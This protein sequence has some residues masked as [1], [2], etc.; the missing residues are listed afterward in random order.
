MISKK[1]IDKLY[2]CTDS[3]DL[4]G[5]E[6][7][8]KEYLKTTDEVTASKDLAI[9]IVND[10][11]SFKAD[12]KAKLMEVIIKC[13]PNLAL[14]NHPENHFF[15]I[16]LVSGS[17]DLF[18]CFIEEAT[19]PHLETADEQEKKE[20]YTK[21]LHLGVQLN[22]IFSDQ[23]TTKIKGV[24]FNGAFSNEG[25]G[26]VKITAEDF[27]VMDDIVNI[28]NTIVGRRDIIKV[29]MTKVGMKF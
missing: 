17:L 25:N 20:Y 27:E 24:D 16:C 22:A 11:T 23:Y 2:D 1:I 13:N 10:Y 28:Y 21:L 19:E 3:G 5:F 29:L 18:E 4:V 7:Y 14:I 6:K 12:A 15:R 8:I 9:F 26:V